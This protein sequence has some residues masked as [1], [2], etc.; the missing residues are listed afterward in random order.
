MNAVK[1]YIPF[2]SVALLMY[3]VLVV[4][5]PYYRFYV[6]P[7]GTAYLT[8]AERYARGEYLQAINGYWSPWSCWLTALLIK[9]GQAPIPASVAINTLG[10][11][12]FLYISQSFFL[13]FAMRRDVQW[14]LLGALGIFLCYAIFAQS[15][16][17]L[18]ECFFLLTTLRLILADDYANKP[19]LWIASGAIGALAYFA[20]AYSFPFFI[21][22]TVC[23]TYAVAGNRGQW[24]RAVLTAVTMMLVLSLPWIYA[25]HSKYGI[26]TT[27]TAG[28]LNTSW[29]LVGHPYWKDDIGALL[30]PA[31]SDSPYYWEDPYMSNGYAPHMW[32][33]LHL[34]GLQFLRIGMNIIKF[35]V[36]LVQLSYFLPVVVLIVVR[37]IAK[38]RYY[39][40]PIALQVVAISFLLFPLGYVPINFESRYIWYMLPLGMVLANAIIANNKTISARGLKENTA[41][42]ALAASV[43][44]YP[45]IQLLKMHNIGKDEYALSQDLAK[46]TG[47]GT[48]FTSNAKPGQQMQAAARTAYFAQM[49]YYTNSYPDRTSDAEVLKEMRRYRINYYF[50]YYRP[51][52]DTTYQMKDEHGTALPV[53]YEWKTYGLKIFKVNEVQ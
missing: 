41:W 22:N 50:Y 38:R 16:D 20:K 49:H 12:G 9:Q 8:I 15:F 10:A 3:V 35:L 37:S 7:D 33:S 29:Y 43:V 18:W 53:V 21:L 36:S 44:I 13:K 17:D 40:Y 48:T 24:I 32:S 1:R 47:V 23:C 45:G 27:S 51:G 11:T 46:E 6:D 25:L 52:G 28:Q 5:F 42:L 19:A 2:F 39:Q 31:Y 34:F 4:I 26:W 14:M 30:P